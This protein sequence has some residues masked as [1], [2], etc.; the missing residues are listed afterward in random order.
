MVEEVLVVD[1]RRAERMQK[2]RGM[3]D[4]GSAGGRT[5]VPEGER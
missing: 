2:V 3:C 1:C 4:C 5:C